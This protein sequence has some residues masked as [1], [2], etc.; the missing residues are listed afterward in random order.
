M[1]CWRWRPTD[2]STAAMRSMAVV[3]A[4]VAATRARSRLEP[5]ARWRPPRPVEAISSSTVASRSASSAS[6]RVDRYSP[7][8]VTSGDRNA[9][10]ETLRRPQIKGPAVETARGRT[11]SAGAF[12][13]VMLAPIS[14]GRGAPT[15]GEVAHFAP[16]ICTPRC[17]GGVPD[18]KGGPP[19]GTR[20]LGGWARSHCRR[21]SY[22][23][24]GYGGVRSHPIGLAAGSV[25][26]G[27]EHRR[28]TAGLPAKA[29]SRL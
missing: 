15:A 26:R 23:S 5:L 12:P 22:R 2:W 29:N 21:S 10:D 13:P 19:T 25:S 27:D 11:W 1:V 8:D 24:G 6:R 20:A 28:N 17:P 16:G 18:D 14:A 7:H 9:P 4:L 3:R